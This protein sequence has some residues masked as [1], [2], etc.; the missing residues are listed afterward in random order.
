MSCSLF[1]HFS[2]KYMNYEELLMTG[3]D[4]GGRRQEGG[5]EFVCRELDGRLGISSSF[6]TSHS[7]LSL[8]GTFSFS[9]NDTDSIC[10]QETHTDTHAD[11]HTHRVQVNIQ[12]VGRGLLLSV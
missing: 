1:I 11:R 2:S 10:G 4:R 5:G 8:S 9:P 7:A 3:R 6:T 12:R